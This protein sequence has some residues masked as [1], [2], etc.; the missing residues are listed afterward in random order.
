MKTIAALT[1]ALLLSTL[2]GATAA[3][4]CIDPDPKTGASLAV[5]V[6][7][8]PLAHTTQ[9]PP[10]D[11]GGAVIGKGNAAAQ[12]G[13]VLD[14]LDAALQDAGADLRR[15]VKLNIYLGRPDAMPAVQA[16]LARR[17]N[18]GTKPAC[19]FVAGALPHPDA[20]VAM[21]A[22]AV[23]EVGGDAVRRLR[24]AAVLPAGGAVYVSG[25]AEKGDL[26]EAT[27]KTLESLRATLEHLGLDRSH[28][29]SV[30]S[31]LQ[32]MGRV[33]EARQVIRDFFGDAPPPMVFV[34]WTMSAPIE[35]ELVA[36]APG[37][38]AAGDTVDYITPP[39]MKASPVYSR[40]ARVNRG[41]HVFV[42]GLYGRKAG[43]A[44]DQI[45]DLFA[46][47]GR[48]LKAAGSDFKHLAKA[49]YY[50]TDE[51]ASKK[52]NELRPEF[53]DPQRP[54]AASKAPVQSVGLPGRS[55]TLDMIAVTTE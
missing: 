45:R 13:A 34:E 7:P 14:A 52:L 36:A 22:V 12:T 19:C 32:P 30:K 43:E 53:Y 15:V 1:V 21:D 39:G 37:R 23:C 51:P 26:K 49:T 31:F 46:E 10:L 55:I 4:R 42:S 35:I 25:Q 24:S 8:A 33:A 20:L 47:L 5:V 40:V 9:L 27:L 17:F 18:T 50:V 29:V 44:G 11:A 41:R 48:L 2:A 38:A 6:D 28:V 54:P 3:V 16:A